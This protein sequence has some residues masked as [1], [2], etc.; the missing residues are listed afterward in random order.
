MW[1][2]QGTKVTERL[3]ASKYRSV[4]TQAEVKLREALDRCSELTGSHLEAEQ[5]PHKLRTAVS[6]QLLQE[7]SVLGGPFSGVLTTLCHELVGAH[8]FES[9]SHR[10]WLSRSSCTCPLHTLQLVDSL[11]PQHAGG[12]Q[13]EQDLVIFCTPKNSVCTQVASI[14]S[15]CFA[16]EDGSSR[17]DQL[18]FFS[19]VDK[20]EAENASYAQQHRAY[21]EQ[22]TEQGALLKSIGNQIKVRMGYK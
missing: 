6:C 19:V 16:S 12:L 15:G 11:H 7:L 17:V 3:T 4:A 14:Y 10:L 8:G 21:Q 5:K 13:K 18:P 20:L 9:P 2:D 22:V 1:G